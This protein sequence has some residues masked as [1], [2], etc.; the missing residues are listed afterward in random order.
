MPECIQSTAT[1]GS[2][3]PAPAIIETRTSPPA[4]SNITGNAGEDTRAPKSAITPKDP[5]G[6]HHRGYLPHFDDQ[7]KIQTITYRLADSLPQELLQRLPDE[8]DGSTG[9]T[10]YRQRIEAHLDRGYGSCCLKNPEIAKMVVDSWL[11]FNTIRYDLYEWVVMPNHVHIL[12]SARPGSTFPIIVKGFKSFTAHEINRV[13]GRRGK[14]W[15]E[16]YWDR[17][18]R[19]SRHFEAATRYIHENPVNAGL[20]KSATDWPWSSVGARVS[21]PAILGARTSP[22]AGSSVPIAPPAKPERRP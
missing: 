16:D 10:A 8:L 22:S 18:I 15:Q 13:L 4:G 6:W 17:Y 9:N 21:P 1:L 3:V 20:A 14:L 11:K 2:W 12:L 5:K 19:N 7:S